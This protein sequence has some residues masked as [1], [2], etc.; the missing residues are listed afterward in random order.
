MSL[1]YPMATLDPR[2]ASLL[3]DEEYIGK[4]SEALQAVER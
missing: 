1:A 2:F 3:T 4:R